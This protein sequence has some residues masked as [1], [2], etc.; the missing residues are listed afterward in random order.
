MSAGLEHGSSRS[1]AFTGID[2]GH[3]EDVFEVASTVTFVPGDRIDF[4]R[5][6]STVQRRTSD[7]V[8]RR[9]GNR[10][11]VSPRSVTAPQSSRTASRTA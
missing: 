9:S 3:R 5:R 10:Y 1:P 11:R 2:R 8:S 4:V 7:A 6:R